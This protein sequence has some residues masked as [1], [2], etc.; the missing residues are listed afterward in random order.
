MALALLSCM[1]PGSPS[2]GLLLARRVLAVETGFRRAP[3]F[4]LETAALESPDKVRQILTQVAAQI[5]VGR[6]NR[7]AHFAGPVR[8]AD[9]YFLV[10][11][12][13]EFQ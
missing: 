7:H 13:R 4:C 9:F 8:Q 10:C 11:G 5:G 3:G 2:R 1:P 12:V 6:V